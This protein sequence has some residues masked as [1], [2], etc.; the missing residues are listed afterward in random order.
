[1][2]WCFACVLC[3]WLLGVVANWVSRACTGEQ[4]TCMWLTISK[5]LKLLL[6]SARS[7]AQWPG[8]SVLCTPDIL[9][10]FLTFVFLTLRSALLIAQ[11]RSGRGTL[12]LHLNLRSLS[13]ESE[14][15]CGA[16]NKASPDR[17]IP[18]PVRSDYWRELTERL[19]N[20]LSLKVL[21]KYKFNS[22]VNF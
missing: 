21:T 8:Q 16:T 14:P 5:L 19:S 12:D 11:D 22:S 9:E 3:S 10:R 6:A 2:L 15:Q 7:M 4:C 1:M 20:T 18:L 17:R 13:P